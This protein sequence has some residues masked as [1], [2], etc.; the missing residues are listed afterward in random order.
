MYVEEPLSASPPACLEQPNPTSFLGSESIVI[1]A[2]S[3]T[4]FWLPLAISVAA[5]IA[6]G[7]YLYRRRHCPT[8]RNPM[9]CSADGRWPI[10]ME[11]RASG[12]CVLAVRQ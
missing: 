4:T 8:G 3:L 2:R 9:M 10:R 5:V 6:L 1:L 11:G 7:P 12:W